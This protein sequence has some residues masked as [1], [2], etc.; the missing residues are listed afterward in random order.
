MEQTDGERRCPN[1]VRP[2]HPTVNL[3][4]RVLGTER[5]R[6]FL[7]LGW[8]GVEAHVAQLAE[9][10]LGK[11]EVSGSIPLMGSRSPNERDWQLAEQVEVTEEVHHG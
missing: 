1:T 2:D 3:S 11:D 8:A 7:P 6:V 10:V 5:V 4:R 9:H